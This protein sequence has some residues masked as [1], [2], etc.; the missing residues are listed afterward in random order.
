M[1]DCNNILSNFIIKVDSLYFYQSYVYLFWSK[2]YILNIIKLGVENKIIIYRK[3]Y[4]IHYNNKLKIRKVKLANN[5][6]S[7]GL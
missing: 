5:Y 7:E 4:N 2:S 6:G 3:G 1:I